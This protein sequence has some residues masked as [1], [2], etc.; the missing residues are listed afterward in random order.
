M[1]K[2][3]KPQKVKQRYQEQQLCIAI[4]KLEERTNYMRS[5]RENS[6]IAIAI[7]EYTI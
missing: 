3:T 1:N 5:N 6:N 4:A 7:L 2:C